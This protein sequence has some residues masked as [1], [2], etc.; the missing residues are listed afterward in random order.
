[1]HIR[2]YILLFLLIVLSKSLSAQEFVALDWKNPSP[3]YVG[4]DEIK[5]DIPG[6]AHAYHLPGDLL[7]YYV[8]RIDLG[9]DYEAFTYDVKVEYPEFQSLSKI[10]AAALK[11]YGAEFPAYPEVTSEISTSAKKGYLVAKFVPIIYKDGTYFRINSFKLTISKTI[12][13]KAFRATT[14]STVKEKYAENS[15]LATGKWVKVRLSETGVYQITKSELSKMGFSDPAKVRLYGYGGNLLYEDLTKPKVDDLQEVPL[16]RESSY[17]LF[18]GRGTIRWDRNESSFVHTQNHYSTYGCYF[19]TESENAPMEFP[20]ENSLPEEGAITVTTFPDYA[21]YE[22]EAFAWH[23]VGRKLFD[24]YDYKQ[25]KTKSY[26]FNDLTGITDDSASITVA[27]SAYDPATTTVSVSVNGNEFAEKMSIG[28]TSSSSYSKAAVTEKTFAWIPDKSEKI[29]VTLTHNRTNISTSGHLDFIRLNYTRKLA[30]YN[31]Y[32]SFRANSLGKTKFVI[33]NAN[34]STYVW[35]VADAGNFRQIQGALSGA[36]YSFV[37]EPSDE[38]EYVVVNTKGSFKKVEVLGVVQNQNLHK[39]S[40]VDMII[41][42]PSKSDFIKQAERLADAHRKHDNLKV[43]IVTSEQVYN[44]FSSGTPDGTAYRWLMKMLYDRATIE[45]RPKYLLL[46]ADAVF[47]NRLLT[48]GWGRFSQNDF[49]LCYG[50]VNSTSD[51]N[52]YVL[53]DYFGLLGDSKGLDI[54]DHSR[55]VVD[56]GVGRFPIRDAVQAKEVTDKVIA[57]MENKNAGVWKNTV[58]FLGDDGKG[59]DEN[60]HMEQADAVSDVAVKYNPSLLVKKVY[61]DAYKRV[62]S[63]TGDSYPEATKR[64]LELFN[65]GTLFFNYTGHGGPTSFSDEYVFTRSDLDNIKSPKAPFW[66]TAACEV[67]PFDRMD[68]T[69]GELAFLHPKGAAIGLLTSTRTVY[70]DPNC[71]MDSVFVR[72]LFANSSNRDYRLGDAIQDAKAHIATT[73]P[74]INNLQ[75]AFIGDPALRLA[76][77]DYKMVV[78]ELNGKSVDAEAPIIK[79]GSEVT[80]KGRILNEDGSLAKDFIGIVHPTVLD[81]EEKITTHNNNGLATKPF[82]YYDRTKT[83]FSG[84]DSVKAG[85]FSFKFPV[86]MDINYSDKSGLLNLYAI[87]NNKVHEGQGVFTNFLIGGT[88]DGAT[89]TDSIGPK[90]NLYL[91]TPDFVYGG[92]VNETPYLVAEL[93]DED[94][95]NTVGNGIGHDIVAIIDNSPALSYTL[96]NYYESILGDYTRGSVR[97][98]LPELSEGKHTILFRAWDIKNN[99][100]TTTL[101]FE[102]VKGLRP[103]LFDV[104][105]TKSPAKDNTTFILTHDRPNSELDINLSVYDF[106]GRV[107]WTHT[108]SGVSSDNYYY[109]DWNLTTGGGQRLNPGIYLFRASISSEGSKQSTKARKIVILGQ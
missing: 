102:V 43:E 60:I 36:Q 105:C 24:D 40:G 63:A 85:T 46:F 5:T 79:A 27:F 72:F 109:I 89:E 74:N 35:D 83:L 15:M 65:E 108:E 25:G 59:R 44:E 33:A 34:E 1:M 30:L 53:D 38:N 62:T 58:C 91:N 16:W 52:S 2:N 32:T 98:S 42:T 17:V 82:T 55:E 9:A 78:D 4:S 76:F 41:I 13:S 47:D 54:N 28:S 66:F 90:I 86:P 93:E 88:E 14:R 26:T 87:D 101:E 73:A 45:D 10:D 70:P 18:Y 57:Y 80:V 37:T 67:T 20:K 103:G 95:I 100:S 3:I 29:I 31:S 19:L 50:S 48:G 23:S 81:N 8:H 22:K 39:L 69:F 71:R 56:I 97:Y 64:I 84:S 94:G 107:L 96:N 21:L 106:A 92:K 61:W 51:T 77:P 6:F 68:D 49:L 104:S 11:K 75:F 99:S 12:G 7:P